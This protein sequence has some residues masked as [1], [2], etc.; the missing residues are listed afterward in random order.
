MMSKPQDRQHGIE[1][2][3]ERQKL[4]TARPIHY[5]QDTELEGASIHAFFWHF[6]I[7]K[8]PS[9]KPHLLLGLFFFFPRLSRSACNSTLAFSTKS[10]HLLLVF[11]WCF[12]RCR[13]VETRW[14]AHTHTHLKRIGFACQVSSLAFVFFFFVFQCAP[15]VRTLLIVICLIHQASCFGERKR[16]G[17]EGGLFSM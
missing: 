15:G 10:T 3:R 5:V 13:C 14:Q 8:T 1:R 2:H 7:Q 16:E 12:R 4:D 6:I 11:P 9:R 17:R